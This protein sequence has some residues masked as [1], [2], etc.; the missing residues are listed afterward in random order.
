MLCPVGSI[1]GSENNFRIQR[2]R[3]PLSN[4]ETVAISDFTEPDPGVI[5]QRNPGITI[6]RNEVCSGAVRNE[7]KAVAIADT[8]QVVAGD[9][10][11]APSGA[12]SRSVAIPAV[13]NCH[14]LPSAKGNIP[15]PPAFIRRGDRNSRSP[16]N[17][18]R[19]GIDVGPCNAT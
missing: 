16:G 1:G 17:A 6:R 10:N 18:V 8:G 13:T 4:V 7:E 12:V 14:K 15:D 11:S 5:G 19:G 2:A 9:L 3:I